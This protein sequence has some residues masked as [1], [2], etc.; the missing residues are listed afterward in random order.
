MMSA[1]RGEADMPSWAGMSASGPLSAPRKDPDP[2]AAPVVNFFFHEFVKSK[3]CPCLVGQIT[4][5]NPPSPRRQGDATRSSRNVGAGCDGRC[6]VRRVLSR[7]T[8][9]P[10]RT[11]KSCGPDAATLASSRL[12]GVPLATVAKKAAH[13]GEHEISCK[14]IA[15]GKPGC[16]GCT[17]SSTRVHLL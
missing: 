2:I 10:Q 7:R 17:C 9:T 13:R 11:A 12:G 16:L 4:G 1:F 3:F 6:G 5:T 8:K 15:R 14:T